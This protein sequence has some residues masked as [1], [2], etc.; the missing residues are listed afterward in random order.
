MLAQLQGS[1][2]L[3]EEWKR[4][5]P[6]AFPN[7]TSHPGC[8]EAALAEYRQICAKITHRGDLWRAAV[9]NGLDKARALQ[10]LATGMR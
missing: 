9:L 6:K 8:D 4:R 1:Q 7:R 2:A 10:D 5:H 3:L